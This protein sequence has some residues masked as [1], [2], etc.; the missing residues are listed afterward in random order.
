M[1][2]MPIHYLAPMTLW[3]FILVQSI[4]N[5]DL[6]SGYWQIEMKE[7][8][9]EKTAFTVGNLGS[10]KCNRMPFGLTNA[11]ATFLIESQFERVPDIFR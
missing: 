8:D 1:S 4:S 9:I 10:Y 2:R 6:R 5:L 7:M 11:P 3:I